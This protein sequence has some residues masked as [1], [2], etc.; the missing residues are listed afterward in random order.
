MAHGWSEFA[1][2]FQNSDWS[3][4]VNHLK[5]QI[6]V[7]YFEAQGGL[8]L[9]LFD[10]VIPFYKDLAF[11]NV[12]LQ[13]IL[14]AAGAEQTLDDELADISMELMASGS[15]VSQSS[16]GS[17]SSYTG[18]SPSRGSNSGSVRS[19]RSRASSFSSTLGRTYTAKL[20]STEQSSPAGERRSAE[21]LSPIGWSR[22]ASPEMAG[23]TASMYEPEPEPV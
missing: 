14:E 20:R 15:G 7:E 18:G 3:D 11:K 23:A 22:P 9:T 1:K 12:S 17:V 6:P 19:T 2:Q 21:Q 10:G 16:T 13:C 4:G 8:T 5:S